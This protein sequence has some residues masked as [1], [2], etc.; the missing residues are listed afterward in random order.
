[1]KRSGRPRDG[2]AHT[3][4]AEEFNRPPDVIER[5]IAEPPR[6]GPSRRKR[7]AQITPK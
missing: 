3:K 5:W 6:P 2:H 7:A 4:I 1:M